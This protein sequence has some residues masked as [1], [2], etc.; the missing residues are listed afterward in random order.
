[1]EPPRLPAGLA[2]LERIVPVRLD[3]LGLQRLNMRQGWRLRPQG[4]D[5]GTHGPVLTLDLNV[6]T[7]GVVEHPP[8]QIHPPGEIIDEGPKPYTLHHPGDGDTAGLLLT[9]ARLCHTCIALR[10][11]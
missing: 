6:N 8:R 2:N 7:A 3:G 1:M 9:Y 11:H 10:R 5:K 4:V